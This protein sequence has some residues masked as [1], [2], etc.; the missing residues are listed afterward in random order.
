M[1][2]ESLPDYFELL[3]QMTGM[4]GGAAMPQGATAG[5][6]FDPAEID[7]KIRELQ[8]V[9]GW[10]QVQANAVELSVKALEYQRDTL[11]AMR[12]QNQEFGKLTGDDL[13][14]FAAA[15]DPAQWMKAVMPGT[16]IQSAPAKPAP[17]RPNAAGKRVAGTSKKR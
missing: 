7:K 12:E 8:T 13:A 9:L 3:R 11:A 6:A 5:T 4:G 16:P 10:L 15:F 14:R 2:N 1:P 17:R